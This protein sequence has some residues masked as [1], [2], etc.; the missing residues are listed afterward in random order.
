MQFMIEAIQ[1]EASEALK[2]VFLH[3]GQSLIKI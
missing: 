2:K 3:L 1:V